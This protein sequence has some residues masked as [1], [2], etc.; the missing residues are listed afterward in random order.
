M[1]AI[2]IIMAM[3]AKLGVWDRAQLFEE[4]QVAYCFGCGMKQ[5]TNRGRRCQCRNDE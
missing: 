1:E 5:D 3:I 2:E 4:I